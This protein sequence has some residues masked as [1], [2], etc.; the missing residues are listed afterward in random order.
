MTSRLSCAGLRAL[1]SCQNQP[2]ETP[3][4]RL[5]TW[6]RLQH[7]TPKPCPT[8]LNHETTKFWL[9]W[10]QPCLVSSTST[11]PSLVAVNESSA[12]VRVFS[13]KIAHYLTFLVSYP[14]SLDLKRAKQ[15][16]V[17]P[18]SRSKKENLTPFA[19]CFP[20]F[21]PGVH[22]PSHHPPPGARR[23]VDPFHLAVPSRS[24]AP[25]PAGIWG[26]YWA[27]RALNVL[28]R[29]GE[30]LQ[31]Q[32]GWT[33]CWIL[34]ISVSEAIGQKSFK[35]GCSNEWLCERERV[36]TVVNDLITDYS[37]YILYIMV[38]DSICK[39]ICIQYI[40]I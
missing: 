9:I 24:E 11:P 31:I 7:F 26:V 25:G 38:N 22:H 35:Q 16:V 28:S 12:D 6:N 5:E 20:L 8:P 4:P 14:R 18:E 36:E 27:C 1:F 23:W 2:T 32:M 17:G 37:H 10:N 34:N 33:S 30:I 21:P 19:L 13:E 15:Q 29:N 39:Y 40:Y 3:K